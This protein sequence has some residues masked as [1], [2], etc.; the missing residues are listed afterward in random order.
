MLTYG[1]MSYEEVV[2]QNFVSSIMSIFCGILLVVLVL[3]LTVPCVVL[4]SVAGFLSLAWAS[5]MVRVRWTRD[6]GLASKC[7]QI[8]AAV[9]QEAV[10]ALKNTVSTLNGEQWEDS[11]FKGSLSLYPSIDVVD[12]QDELHYDTF[13]RLTHHT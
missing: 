10:L 13:G 12:Q 4:G 11:E 5:I 2:K 7:Q 8:L 3:A 1:S 9:E 6:P